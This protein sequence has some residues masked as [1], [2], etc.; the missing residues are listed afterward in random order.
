MDFVYFRGGPTNFFYSLGGIK[1]N[2]R[3]IG[4]TKGIKA[5]FFKKGHILGGVMSNFF[6]KGHILGGVRHLLASKF[7]EL[8]GV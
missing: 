6:K 2:F 4:K 1:R 5:N 3:N 7:H 8:G